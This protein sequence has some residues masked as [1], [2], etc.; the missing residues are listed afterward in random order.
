MEAPHL[1]TD[2]SKREL[3]GKTGQE[4]RCLPGSA[5]ACAK[6]RRLEWVRLAREWGWGRGRRWK[7][8]LFMQGLVAIERNVTGKQG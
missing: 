2:T 5:T 7:L 1:A 6:A 8:W 4:G 3:T